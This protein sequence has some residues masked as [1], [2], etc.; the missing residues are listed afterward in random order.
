[1]YLLELIHFLFLIFFFW[2]SRSIPDSFIYDYLLY[3]HGACAFAFFFFFFCEFSQIGNF[4]VYLFTLFLKVGAHC[5]FA[6]G[7]V[8]STFELCASAFP[9]FSI[10]RQWFRA[11]TRSYLSV[12]GEYSPSSSVS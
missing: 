10:S 4:Y 9:I 3:L 6:S 12:P 11:P 7:Q 2:G 5:A 8:G 1:M